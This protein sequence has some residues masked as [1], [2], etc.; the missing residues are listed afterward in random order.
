MAAVDTPDAAEDEKDPRAERVRGNADSSDA[1]GEARR[2]LFEG[3]RRLERRMGEEGRWHKERRERKEEREK[4][5]KQPNK[6][7]A[8]NAARGEMGGEGCAVPLCRTRGKASR[9]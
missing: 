4:R 3:A 1:L 6:E 2:G 5:R 8:H 7:R 9:P